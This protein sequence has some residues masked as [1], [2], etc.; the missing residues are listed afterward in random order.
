MFPD[1]GNMEQLEIPFK[2]NT[3]VNGSQMMSDETKRD[4]TGMYYI[5]MLQ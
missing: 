2:E 3:V 4:E 5:Y 1:H